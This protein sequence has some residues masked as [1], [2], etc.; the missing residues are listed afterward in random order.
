MYIFYNW[1]KLVQ[2]TTDFVRANQPFN[3]LVAKSYSVLTS[4]KSIN[5]YVS[6]ERTI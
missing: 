5:Q 4:N 2:R 1:G 6:R 3:Y